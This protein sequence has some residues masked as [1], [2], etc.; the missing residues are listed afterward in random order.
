MLRRTLAATLALAMLSSGMLPADAPPP[1]PALARGLAQMRDGDFEAAVLSLDSAVRAIEADRSAAAHRGWA[2]VYLGVAYLE[3]EQEAVARGKF[4]EALARDPA[5]RLE[6]SEFSAQSIRIFEDVRAEAAAVAPAGGAARTMPVPVRT[7]PADRE[8]KGSKGPLVA[9]LLGGA[10]AAGAAV[11]LGGGGGDNPTTT[12]TAP[13][14]PSPTPTP[15]ATPTPGPT[16][17]P[18]PTPTPA[19]T[20]TPEPTPTPPPPPPPACTYT[21]NGPTPPN[22]YL[23][24]G[25]VGTCSVETQAGCRWTARSSQPWISVSGS[26]SGSGVIQFTL[27]A[28]PDAGQRNGSIFLAESP[29]SSCPIQQRGLLGLAVR[30]GERQWTSILEVDGAS[31]HVVV[32]GSRSTYQGRGAMR[33]TVLEDGRRTHHVL[34]TLVAAAGRPGT[35]RFQLPEGAANVRVVAGT[36]GALAAD[37]V[38]FRLAGRPGE[39]LAFTFTGR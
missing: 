11:A 27:A 12:T 31:A 25:G 4:R 33:M 6:P 34:A 7:A 13:P 10:A 3:L 29:S 23:Q 1:H 37:S 16:P 15:G 28:N 35:W 24:V 32:D 17:D 18:G 20:P 9:V 8:T 2:Y 26:A 39:R 22:P 38:T 36:V 5:L 21:V 14:G 19:P 30:D